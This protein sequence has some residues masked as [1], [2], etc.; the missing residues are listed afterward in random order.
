MYHPPMVLVLASASPRR[1]ELLAAAGYRFVVDP[2]FCDESGRPGEGPP[3]Y[4]RRVA[5]DKA[6]VVAARH[7][8]AIVLGADTVVVVEGVVL[9][10]PADAADAARM[11]RLLS[12]RAHDVLTAVSVRRGSTHVQHLESTTVRFARLRDVEIA[13]YVSTGEPADKAGAYAVQ[14]LASRYVEAVDGSYSNVVGLPVAPLYRILCELGAEP[15]DGDTGG[16]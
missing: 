12:G 7:P 13:W 16:R 9:G 11:L 2:A 5:A 3:D 8:G 6:A 4:A 15:G 10:K 1:A 14:G